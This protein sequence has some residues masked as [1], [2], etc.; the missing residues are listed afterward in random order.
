MKFKGE[1]AFYTVMGK[2]IAE[3]VDGE[4]NTDDEDT[5]RYLKGIGFTPEEEASSEP[6]LLTE[7][8]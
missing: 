8:M 6:D 2:P 3:F 5:I 7:R 4:C 1:G